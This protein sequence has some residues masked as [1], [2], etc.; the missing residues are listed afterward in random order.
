MHTISYSGKILFEPENKTK[1]HKDQANWKKV[2]MVVFDDDIEGEAFWTDPQTI[3]FRPKV[4][5]EAGK[6]YT[7]SFYLHKLITVK[8]ELKEF[9]F[10]L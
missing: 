10:G 3:E 1:K 4:R 7:C 9:E 8:D 5:L 6:S 2:A